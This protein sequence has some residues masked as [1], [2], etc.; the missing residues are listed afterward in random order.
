MGLIRSET[1]GTRRDDSSSSS[2]YETIE[3]HLPTTRARA[4]VND[5][6]SVE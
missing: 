6:S 2:S 3:N 1:F 4:Q 5:S